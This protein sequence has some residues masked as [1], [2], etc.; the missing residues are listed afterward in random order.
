MFYFTIHDMYNEAT[1]LRN[2]DGAIKNFNIPIRLII[3][4]VEA[5]CYWN[6]TVILYEY[7]DDTVRYYYCDVATGVIIHW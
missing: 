6:V 1:K 3:T 4:W 2:N 5:F 7:L